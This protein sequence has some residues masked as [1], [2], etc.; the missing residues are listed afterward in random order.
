M[1]PPS[2]PHISVLK[3]Q[4]RMDMQAEG[5]AG[6]VWQWHS[7]ELPRG[8]CRV[9]CVLDE[10]VAC[11]DL[12]EAEVRFR[13][14]L[15]SLVCDLTRGNM[16]VVDVGIRELDNMVKSGS[17]RRCKAASIANVMA[18]HPRGFAFGVVYLV[19]YRTRDVDQ[20][21]CM[22]RVLNWGT[23][24]HVLS[25]RAGRA[26]AV[27]GHWPPRDLTR[28]MFSF[29]A[30]PWTLYN[31]DGSDSVCLPTQYTLFYTRYGI[32]LPDARLQWRRWHARLRKRQWMMRTV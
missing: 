32:A 22:Q 6:T 4:G 27:V 23:C 16:D 9:P 26:A 28:N 17:V 8:V 7:V 19:R 2:S 13:D 15:W 5:A 31:V 29:G 20:R 21:E 11:S 25:Y 3:V 18:L 12:S 30:L 24:P 1:P 14:K 10:H